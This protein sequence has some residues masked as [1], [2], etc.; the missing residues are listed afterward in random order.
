MRRFPQGHSIHEAF[1]HA[2]GYPHDFLDTLAVGEDSGRV[3][4]SM[5]LLARQYQDQARAALWR[6]WR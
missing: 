5:G 4:E 6:S 3:V 1:C 2:G